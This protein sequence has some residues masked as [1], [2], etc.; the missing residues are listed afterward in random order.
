MTELSKS[1]VRNAIAAGDL[2]AV[3]IKGRKGHKGMVRIPVAAYAEWKNR[4]FQKI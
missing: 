4:C 2:A 3:K 1:S